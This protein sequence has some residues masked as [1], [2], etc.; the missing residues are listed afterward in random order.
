MCIHTFPPGHKYVGVKCPYKPNREYCGYHIKMYM[1]KK[2]IK[3]IVLPSE[4]QQ[5]IIR[6]KARITRKTKENFCKTKIK[7]D[8]A[9]I[10]A[11]M[12]EFANKTKSIENMLSITRE[13]IINDVEQMFSQLKSSINNHVDQY[14]NIFAKQIQQYDDMFSQT[15]KNIENQIIIAIDNAMRNVNKYHTEQKSIQPHR[16]L[17]LANLIRRGS[18]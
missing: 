4:E 10:K 1:E 17:S 18:A 15:Q 6:S 5:V 16:K 11:Y 8:I 13:S 2:N 7:S 14:D 9:Q 12:H 3:A